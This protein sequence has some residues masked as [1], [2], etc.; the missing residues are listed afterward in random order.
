MAKAQIR[1]GGML[2]VIAVCAGFF[3]MISLGIRGSVFGRAGSI[4]LGGMLV[5]FLVHAL[6]YFAASPFA[7]LAERRVRATKS[8][9]FAD[10]SLPPKQTGL[11]E[12]E[13]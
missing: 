1:L 7:L 2:I 6:L 13:P 8:T 4:V 9:P 3:A 12:V 5:F 10:S 11:E